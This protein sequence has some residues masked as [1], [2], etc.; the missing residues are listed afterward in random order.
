M[1]IL[2]EIEIS[3]VNITQRNYIKILSVMIDVLFP[4]EKGE[5]CYDYSLKN[6]RDNTIQMSSQ[7]VVNYRNINME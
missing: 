6:M 2:Y 5:G 4:I 7:Q 3:S 1:D